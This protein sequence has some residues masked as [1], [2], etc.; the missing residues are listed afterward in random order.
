MTHMLQSKHLLWQQIVRSESNE[1]FKF[2]NKKDSKAYDFEQLSQNFDVNQAFK[3]K[4]DFYSKHL[5]KY[6]GD[7]KPVAFET[8][9]SL[10][11]DKNSSA[12]THRLTL[13]PDSS[14]NNIQEG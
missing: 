6:M 4:N 11:I 9:Q 12:F 7:T 13:N 14:F 10:Q 8:V 3:M 5:T 1:K 2:N